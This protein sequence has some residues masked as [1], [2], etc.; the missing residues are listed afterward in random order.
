MPLAIACSPYYHRAVIMSFSGN[1]TEYTLDGVNSW[2]VRRILPKSA[3]RAAAR[4]LEQ[5]DCTIALE[6]QPY[7]NIV[8]SLRCRRDDN[9]TFIPVGAPGFRRGALRM[10][11]REVL[12]LG[13]EVEPLCVPAE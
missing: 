10:R 1:G 4:T 3:W 9:G 5:L 6:D 12:S 8:S 2:I 7:A 11:I 13:Q